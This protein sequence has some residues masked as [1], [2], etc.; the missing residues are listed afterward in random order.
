MA[1]TLN[2][3]PCSCRKEMDPRLAVLAKLFGEQGERMNKAGG[4]SG[5]FETI[6]EVSQWQYLRKSIQS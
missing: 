2:L 3:G 1:P 5:A 6:K 4:D